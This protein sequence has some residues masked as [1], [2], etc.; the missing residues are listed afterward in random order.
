MMLRW[1]E[2]Q[3]SRRDGGVTEWAVRS[4]GGFLLPAGEQIGGLQQERLLGVDALQ[5]A[6]KIGA[7]IWAGACVGEMSDGSIFA[8][9]VGYEWVRAD[10]A[11]GPKEVC[12]QALRFSGQIE[13]VNRVFANLLV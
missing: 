3:K 4:S 5:H 12:V 1:S 7:A 2:S 8:S 11:Y 13:V 6:Q 9:W 10:C